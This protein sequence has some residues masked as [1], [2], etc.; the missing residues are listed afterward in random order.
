MPNGFSFHVRYSAT[1]VTFSYICN[2]S[3]ADSVRGAFNVVGEVAAG[4]DE[5]EIRRMLTAELD[6]KSIYLPPFVIE[7]LVGCLAAGDA[8]VTF[9]DEKE[10]P[11]LPRTGLVG[12]LAGRL[13]GRI[14]A[15]AVKGMAEEAISGSQLFSRPT[16][17]AEEP[18]TYV[19]G[20]GQLPSPA[21]V[22]I[23]SDIAERMP[24]LVELPNEWATG[25]SAMRNA[26][27]NARLVEEDA[28]VV[29][30]YA[31]SGRVGQLGS[32]DAEAYLPHLRSARD[33][34][35]QVA[36]VANRRLTGRRA[37]LITV[38]FPSSK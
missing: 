7:L 17:S 14:F 33:H 27:F 3:D 12:S 4:K 35:K 19:P 18:N 30:V 9:S 21:K 5:T 8:V 15:P 1:G 24:W 31:F 32:K 16:P 11:D 34:G 36:V 28:A 10:P 20:P 13:I 37:L 38:S 6:S 22:I 29:A 25:T 26:S 2:T 23:D